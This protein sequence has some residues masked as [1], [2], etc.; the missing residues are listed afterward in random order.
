MKKK[1]SKKLDCTWDDN[2]WIKEYERKRKFN[3]AVYLVVS[4]A[5]VLGSFL[6]LIFI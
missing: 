2:V 6:A 1:E 5:A 4:V 3:D